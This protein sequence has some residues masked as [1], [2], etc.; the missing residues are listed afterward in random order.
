MANHVLVRDGGQRV[1]V[2]VTKDFVDDIFRE[3]VPNIFLVLFLDAL[4]PNFFLVLSL[5][6]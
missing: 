2:M 5:F 6:F 1:S 4:G 3:L